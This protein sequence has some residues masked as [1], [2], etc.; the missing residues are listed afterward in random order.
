V[1]LKGANVGGEV[2]D[3]TVAELAARGA[4]IMGGHGLLQVSVGP[5]P[6]RSRVA[7]RAFDVGCGNGAAGAGALLLLVALAI[8]LEDRGP[9]F[10][11]QRRVGRG[12]RFSR[13]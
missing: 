10:F 11:I 1:I 9:V 2:I 12:N 6:L 13:S 3:D 7:K 4:R 5:L 8:K